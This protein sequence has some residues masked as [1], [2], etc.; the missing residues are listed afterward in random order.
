MWKGFDFSFFNYLS[1]YIFGGRGLLPI[2]LN[3]VWI[4]VEDLGDI[5]GPR[6]CKKSM[7]KPEPGYRRQ[8]GKLQ[9]GCAGAASTCF[10]FCTPKVSWLLLRRCSSSKRD[11][12]RRFRS[13]P[14]SSIGLPTRVF[15]STV[16]SVYNPYM[17]QQYFQL[18]GIPGTVNTAVYPFG[19]L[20]QPIPGG[21]GYTAVQGYTIPGHN[22]AQFTGPNVNGVTTA[23]RPTIQAPYPAGVA[24]PIP[25]PPHFLVTAH[26]P[27]FTQGSSSDQT[28]G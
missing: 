27:Q 16:W 7:R 24:A 4:G 14:T 18:Y 3:G 25:P 9:L 21:H 8:T 10:N 6:I 20:G 22:F 12:C 19:Q 13:S 17:G 23:P 1:L 5:S 26:S 15:I 28:A 2:F 11:L